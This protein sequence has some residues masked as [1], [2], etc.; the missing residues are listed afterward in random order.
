M[1]IPGYTLHGDYYLADNVIPNKTWKEACEMKE[2]ITLSNGKK[3]VAHTFSKEELEIISKKERGMKDCWYWTSTS[4]SD[5]DNCA[6][7]VIN[8]G[9]FYDSYVSFSFSTGGARLGF[10]KNEIKQFLDIE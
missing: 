3:V 10:H 7:C 4:N 2:E 1:K 6:W 9:D 8:I 5:Y